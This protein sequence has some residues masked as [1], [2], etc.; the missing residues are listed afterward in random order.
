MEASQMMRFESEK[1]SA[2]AA[3]ILNLV[4]PG[5]GYMYCGYVGLGIIAMAFCLVLTVCT[6]GAALIIIEPVMLIDGILCAGR[7]NK[8]LAAKILSAA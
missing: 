6:L 3:A 8:A 4:L 1:K 2:F 7:A 5:A